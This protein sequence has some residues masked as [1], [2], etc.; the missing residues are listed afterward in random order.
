MNGTACVTACGELEVATDGVCVCREDKGI[1][2]RDGVCRCNVDQYLLPDKS[3]CMREL[4]FATHD[5]ERFTCRDRFSYDS[6][7]KSCVPNQSKGWR[8]LQE[9]CAAEGWTTTLTYDACISE[10][11]T[12][13]T[14]VDH[15]C[16]CG[17]GSALSRDGTSCVSKT[18]E[19]CLRT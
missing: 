12:D 13:Q 15:H 8:D 9:A 11:P 2:L 16:R 19:T 17:T 5:E 3:G 1:V 10:C 18:D 7:T 4:V 6:E 14:E